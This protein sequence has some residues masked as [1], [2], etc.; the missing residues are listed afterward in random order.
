MEEEKKANKETGYTESQRKKINLE[1]TSDRGNA[2][3]GKEEML[4][5]KSTFNLLPPSVPTCCCPSFYHQRHR[6][7]LE[8]KHTQKGN[9]ANMWR[10]T[11]FHLL[12]RQTKS[13]ERLKNRTW[14]WGIIT[15]IK[16]T[17][18]QSKVIGKRK[19]TLLRIQHTLSETPKSALS[20]V[21][22]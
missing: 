1:R 9:V 5:V 4:R 22:A 14:A 16:S 17:S 15:S 20:D 19:S 12:L 18:R 2:Q 10:D 8:N 3:G 7:A 13:S 6:K 21:A 11:N